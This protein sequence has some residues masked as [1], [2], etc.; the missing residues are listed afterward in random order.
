MLNQEGHY[1][2]NI[3]ETLADE[4]MSRMGLEKSK[5]I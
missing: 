4:I 3:Q 2:K 5:L 1:T